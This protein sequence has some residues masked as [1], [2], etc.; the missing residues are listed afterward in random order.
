MTE[1][2][3]SAEALILAVSAALHQAGT[4]PDNA[5]LVAQA[6]VA[7][8]ID[9]HAGH[10]ISRVASYAA[11]AR[12]GK[13]DGHATPSLTWA[14]D[15]VARV[16][17]GG[18]FAFPAL[19]MARDALAQRAAKYGLAAAAIFRSHHFGQA[20]YT[21]EKLAEQGLVA[22]LLGNSPAAIAPHGGARPL[23]GTNPL[24]AAFPR[25]SAPLVI[26]VSLAKMARGKVMVAARDNVA[27]PEGVALDDKGHPTTDAKAALH[28]SMLPI[29]DAKGAGLALM[30]ELFAA[31]VVGANFGFE[32]TSFF[33][34]RGGPPL[35][36][37]LLVAFAPGVLSGGA[38]EARLEAMIAAMLAQ[39]GVRLPG[40]TRLARRDKALAQGLVVDAATL[41]QIRAL[42]QQN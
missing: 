21:V 38:Y 3:I 34:A 18:G 11:Q 14:T 9:G 2:T 1:A 30:V 22:L 32:A 29:G 36:G 37:Q 16:D 7:A 35:V 27:L 24:A 10:G 42:A 20:G 23:L 4:A 8:E 5:K 6:L 41:D 40:S 17:A 15:A 31:A 12:S 26:D 13:V 28:G 39:P 25:K 19:A 33:D